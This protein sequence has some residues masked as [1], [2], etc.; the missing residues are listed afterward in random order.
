M[1]LRCKCG[2]SDLKVYT[3]KDKSLRIYCS[4]C[5]SKLKMEG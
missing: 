1:Q 3:N 5:K 2:C 4:K